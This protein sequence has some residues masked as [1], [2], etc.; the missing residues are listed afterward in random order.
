[1]NCPELP[2]AQLEPWLPQGEAPLVI[3][4]PCSAESPEQLMATAHAL[5]AI[6]QVRVFRAGLWKP[7]TRPEGFQGVGELGLEWMQAV[8]AET[9]LLLT[10]EVA[11]P[12]HVEEA[13]KAGID[14]LWVGA[15]TSGNPFSMQEIADALRGTEV[16]VMVKNPLNP[17]LKLWLGALERLSQAGI[18][19][20]AAIHRGF[21]PYTSSRFRHDPM[22]EVPIELKRHCTGLPLLCDP[23][24]ISGSTTLIPG[25]S[26]K[27][28]DLA[29]D[30]LMIEVHVHPSQALTD[31][32]QQLS[33]A[34][35]RQ[36]LE[37]L[38]VR[39]PGHE[40]ALQDMLAE[41]RHQIDELDHEML[42]ILD[43]RMEIVRR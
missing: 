18:R 6:P 27:A 17:D 21:Y 22:W 8:K 37:Q 3:A 14:I 32:R 40:P 4:G 24:H 13:L 16:P 30:G 36:M 43:R 23:S 20:L 5:A 38:V 41:L 31:K 42:R 28:L 26:Q 34:Q 1:M 19:R 12:G 39:R 15:R 10:V 35:L 9:G 2:E 33:P 7:R 11:K 29:M 25:I